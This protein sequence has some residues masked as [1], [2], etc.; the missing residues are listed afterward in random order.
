MLDHL[1]KIETEE[2]VNSLVITAP[3]VAQAK[4]S[5]IN[6]IHLLEIQ[7]N[8][9]LKSVGRSSTTQIALSPIKSNDLRN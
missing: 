2:V 5:L 1:V 6:L 8:S 7:I 4:T 9:L 3:T